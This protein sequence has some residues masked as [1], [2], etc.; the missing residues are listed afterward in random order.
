MVF[1][2]ELHLTS[3]NRS[4]CYISPAATASTRLSYVAGGQREP[5]AQLARASH[6]IFDD[7]RRFSNALV[8][9]PPMTA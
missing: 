1:D 6:S 3:C 7:R 5:D 4:F 2:R 8:V 9:T